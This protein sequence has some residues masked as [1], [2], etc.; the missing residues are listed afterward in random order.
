[1]AFEQIGTLD[2][3]YDDKAFGQIVSPAEWNDNFKKIET[4]VNEH[5]TDVNGNFTSLSN[6]DNTSDLNKPISTATQIAL[7]ALDTAKIDETDAVT[8]ATP[9]KIL[10]LD[11]SGK[12]PA[13]VTG[14]ADATV[15][16]LNTHKASSDHDSHNATLHYTKTNMQTTGQAQVHWGNLTNVPN[17]ADSSWKSSVATPAN[18]PVTGNTLGDQ[19]VVLN[20]GDGKQA[21]YICVATTG[22]YDLQWDKI[23][24]VDWT[25][26]HSGLVG[27]NNDDHTQYL[28]PERGDVRYNTK[29]EITTALAGK[30][31][32]NHNHS[33]VYVSVTGGSLGSNLDFA[34]FEGKNFVIDNEVTAPL[35][36]KVGQPW[37][38]T[39]SNKLFVYKGLVLGWVDVSGKG[40]IIKT[41]EFI[42]T[43]GQTVFDLTN[44]GLYEVGTNTLTFYKKSATGKYELLDADDYTESSSV[45]ITLDSG[46]LIGE[47]YLA[48]W[49]ENNPE[50]VNTSVQKD[51]TLQVNLNADMLDGTHLAD[52]YAYIN[53]QFTD[54][55][56]VSSNTWYWNSGTTTPILTE[57]TMPTGT[58]S[59]SLTLANSATNYTKR[60]QFTPGVEGIW[61]TKSVYR[62]IFPTSGYQNNTN[63]TLTI[64]YYC[65]TTLLRTKTITATGTQL[66]TAGAIQE[67]ITA[68]VRSTNL[69]YSDTD[70]FYIDVVLSRSNGTSHS[71]T[72]TTST[73][74][75]ST[76]FRTGGAVGTDDVYMNIAGNIITQTTM[77]N[78]L[79]DLLNKPGAT[80][81]L[82][83]AT[84]N[85]TT[86]DIGKL[87]VCSSASEI[88]LFISP[89]SELACPIDTEIVIVRYGTGVVS[90]NTSITLK[91]V[92]SKRTIRTQYETV[93]LKK[94]AVDEWLLLGALA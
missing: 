33:G 1:M 67:D 85:I 6:V 73:T 39:G 37:Y 12:L 11:T 79:I 38:D 87:L 51:G 9:S 10:K 69:L 49:F 43:A 81:A 72:F 62:I 78:S 15:D 86:G 93:T 35:N 65:N 17:M 16:K 56:T 83:T 28:T 29:S 63:Y 54:Q 61:S 80:S 84:R 46:A 75:P 60:F 20:D 52:I 74:N 30:S 57:N 70:V 88:N 24:D 92:A 68:L 55:V 50:I 42:T 23:G 45:T 5:A 40:A 32:T 41:K 71:I 58:L 34:G 31:N 13:S 66:S 90:F 76:F 2:V 18:L 8:V 82:V 44:V 89:D 94:I 19:R 91:S 22:T 21:V 59:T 25:N 53:S 14:D 3:V 48:R 64:N 26:A 4:V 77:N 27:L 7:T 36:P 47:E